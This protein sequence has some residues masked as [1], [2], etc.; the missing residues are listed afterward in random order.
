MSVEDR[1]RD[2]ELALVPLMHRP[3]RWDSSLFGSGNYETY[4]NLVV[5]QHQIGSWGREPTCIE[6]EREAEKD[7]RVRWAKA[8]P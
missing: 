2:V 4:C 5:R 6:C 1:A 3:K 8:R 7:A